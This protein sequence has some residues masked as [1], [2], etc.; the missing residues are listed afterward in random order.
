MLKIRCEANIPGV[1]HQDVRGDAPYRVHTCQDD[2]LERH[3]V[4]SADGAPA[5]GHDDDDQPSRAFARVKLNFDFSIDELT[6]L[7]LIQ[8]RRKTLIVNQKLPLTEQ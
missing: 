6:T 7:L 4:D 3:V 8:A 5:V 2:A 1:V